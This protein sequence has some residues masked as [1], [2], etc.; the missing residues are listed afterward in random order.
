MKSSEEREEEINRTAEMASVFLAA[1]KD[2]LIMSSRELI[3]GKCLFLD[4]LWKSSLT[5]QNPHAWIWNNPSCFWNTD[6][7]S[8]ILFVLKVI[9]FFF[10]IH[11]NGNCFTFLLIA[12]SESLEINFKVSSALVEVVRRI[13]TR[14]RYFLAKV[15]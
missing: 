10:S 2:T 6:I 12:A 15:L 13:T 14:P 5:T 9:L 4:S 8:I 3:T 1:R 7:S 11:W